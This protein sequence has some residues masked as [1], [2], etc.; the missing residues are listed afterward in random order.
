[1][2]D[3]LQP[4]GVLHSRL[5]CPSPTPRVYSNPCPL[6]RWCYPTISSSVVLFSSCPQYFPASAG[7]ISNESALHIRWPQYWSFS[8]SVSSSS[9]HPGL[10][11][12]R[13]DWFDLL[14]VQGTLKGLFQHHFSWLWNSQILACHW[15]L[16][17]NGI[18]NS[19]LM[20][21]SWLPDWVPPQGER[22]FPISMC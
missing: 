11:S 15:T 1:M 5:P 19:F 10:I 21:I 14:A 2:S 9:E 6:S 8:F 3:S 7:K 12:S 13:M 4:H 17:D 22:D 18:K 16:R 20:L